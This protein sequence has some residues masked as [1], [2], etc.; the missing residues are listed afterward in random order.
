MTQTRQG[1]TEPSARPG[2]LR[3]RLTAA[4][5]AIAVA[6]TGLVGAGFAATS[7]S[8]AEQTGDS[9][10]NGFRNV[11]YFAQWGVYGRNFQVKDIDT[12]GEAS[13]LTHINYAFGNIHHQNLT[14]F[15]ANKAQ[16]D[17]PNGSDGAGDAY[18][19]YGKSYSAAASVSGK[20]DAWDQPLAGSFNQLKQLKAKHPQLRTLLSLGGWTWSKNFS[21]AAATDASREKLVSSCIDMFIK[22]DLPK[23]DGRG[24]PGAAAGVFDG[25]DLDWEWPGSNN[26]LAGNYVDEVNDKENFRLL[27]EEFRTQL[28][29]YGAQTGKDYLLTAFL[30]ANPADIEVGGWNDPGTSRTSTSG[31][32]RA[33]TSRGRGTAPGPATRAT[34]TTTRSR[35]DRTPSATASSG[36]SR[37]TPTRASTRPSSG[38]GSPCTGAAGRASRTPR[39][40]VARSA[41]L[42][43]PGNPAT[44]TTTS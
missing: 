12:S 28:D 16:Q 10:I 17:G 31:T 1:R 39:P 13:K 22:G 42:P 36:R 30:P 6:G 34:C 11:A 29:A 15:E 2:G 37:S 33:T 44:R 8:A 7:A 24:G 38:S 19:D 43:A 35:R 25:F 21:R 40:G 4:I 32:S 14:C 26:G 27:I 3:R 18:A 23:I 9:A 20:A 41:R 5:A